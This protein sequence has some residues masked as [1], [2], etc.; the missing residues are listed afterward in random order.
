[1][2]LINKNTSV[3]YK[4]VDFEINIIYKTKFQTGEFFE[5]KEI[6]RK[7]NGDIIRFK[8]IYLSHPHLDICPLDVDRL[9]PLTEI[10]F[11][12][13]KRCKTCNQVIE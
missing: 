2:E 12:N 9:H 3:E 13:V 8:G 6:I 7:N 1:M 11:K 5:V 4:V 10:I